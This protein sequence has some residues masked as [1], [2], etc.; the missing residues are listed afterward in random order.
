[1]VAGRARVGA[2]ARCSSIPSPPPKFI[3]DCLDGV[4]FPREWWWTLIVI[5]T[6][7]AVG[8]LAGIWIPGVA[9]AANTGVIIYFVSA[10]VAHFR[11]R[12]TGQAFWMNCLGMLALSLAVQVLSYVI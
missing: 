8:L 12:F 10:A 1:M 4:G 3:R 7:A 5:K 6:T 11:A 9:F 2:S